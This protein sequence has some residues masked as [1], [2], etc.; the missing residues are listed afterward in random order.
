M[1]PFF[2]KIRW[3]LAQD[4][5]FLKYSRYAIGEIVLVV[6]G[7][8]IALQINNWN[9]DRKIRIEEVRALRDLKNEFESNH[10]VLMNLYEKKKFSELQNRIYIKSLVS[11]SLSLENKISLTQP[12]FS[13]F[14]LR[15]NYTILNSL[16]ISGKL[17]YFKNEGLKHKLSRWP[18]EIDYYR[19]YE[20][21]HN[22]RAIPNL[23]D[24]QDKLIPGQIL[25][26]NDSSYFAVNYQRIDKVN[27]YRKTLIVNLEFQNAIAGIVNSLFIKTEILGSLVDI[28]NVLQDDLDKEIQN[29]SN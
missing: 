12:D 8:L 1:L 14:N 18:D 13:G 21:V 6:I 7:I 25:G 17:D 20:K 15:V 26:K 4:N 3:R 23:L 9:E 11:D 2:R 5:Q 22:E 10:N 16:L 19:Q 29:R 24:I 28:S 27:Q